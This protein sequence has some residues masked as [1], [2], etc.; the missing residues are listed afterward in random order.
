MTDA[1][2]NLKDADEALSYADAASN[3]IVRNLQD[4]HKLLKEIRARTDDR[5]TLLLIEQCMLKIE[6]QL[7]Y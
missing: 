3:G 4:I 6:A 5:V 2:D 1:I 7:N